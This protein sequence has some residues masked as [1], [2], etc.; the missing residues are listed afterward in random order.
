MTCCKSCSVVLPISCTTTLFV[1]ASLLY[2]LPDFPF[3]TH[4]MSFASV[5]I[6]DHSVITEVTWLTCLQQ[7]SCGSSL[8]GVD[9]M[10]RMCVSVSFRYAPMYGTCQRLN[11]CMLN[12][13]LVHTRMQTCLKYIC[14][15]VCVCA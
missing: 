11:I 12:S 7:L 4:T 10:H 14:N 9:W 13:T 2:S 15:D 5:D 8:T 6:D 1:Y 3:Q